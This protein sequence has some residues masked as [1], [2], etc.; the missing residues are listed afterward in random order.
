M[1]PGHADPR[2]VQLSARSHGFVDA[3]QTVPTA[4][5]ASAGHA[6]PVPVQFSATSHTPFAGRQTVLAGA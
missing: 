2:P 4:T 1:F 6:L 5:N 3:R